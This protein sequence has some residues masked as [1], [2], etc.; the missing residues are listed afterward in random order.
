MDSRPNIRCLSTDYPKTPLVELGY[1]RSPQDVLSLIRQHKP[2]TLDFLDGMD[3]CTSFTQGKFLGKGKSGSVF[4]I[5]ENN[6]KGLPVVLKEFQAKEAPIIKNLKH[7]E[8]IYVLSSSLNDIV[9]SSLFHSFYDG[10]LD[11]CITFPYFE[12][13]FVCDG[14]GYSIIEQLDKTM[15]QYTESP[16]F[17]ADVFKSMLFQVIYA[18]RF[19]NLKNV[20]HND[21]HGKN[22]MTRSTHGISYRGVGLDTV[23]NF[24]Y[25]DGLKTYI[26]PNFG[27]IAKIMDFDFACKYS[28][29]AIC[30]QKVYSKAEDKWNLQFR[31][32]LTYDVLV[33]SAYMVYYIIIKTPG[34]GAV[35]SG[36]VKKARW[37][38]ENLAEYIVAQT[39]AQ[40]GEIPQRGHYEQESDGKK[41]PRDAVSKLMDMVSVPQY[42]PYE[43]YCHLLLPEILNIGAFQDYQRHVASSLVVASM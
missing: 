18:T 12:G 14:T 35:D 33:F 26:H 6:H 43:K 11:F 29:P 20:V 15:A 7:G 3:T 1:S 34:K 41:R 21:M 23:P 27:T 4:T 25:T 37:V 36:E 16:E 42:R 24:A 9:M 2:V 38:V 32:S 30:P 13:F 10:G 17:R 19:M 5:E 22:V 28:H 8:D 40:V 39:E 31:F